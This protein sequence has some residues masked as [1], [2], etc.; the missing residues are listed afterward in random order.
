MD[1]DE[2]ATADCC[3]PVVSADSHWVFGFSISLIVVFLY[4]QASVARKQSWSTMR[5]MMLTEIACHPHHY[6]CI[7]M[8]EFESLIV[9]CNR[10]QL[11][12]PVGLGVGMRALRSTPEARSRPRPR[13]TRK[14]RIWTLGHRGKLG[15]G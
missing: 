14:R 10:Y 13:G 12:L 9:D 15:A 4:H 3:G 5:N 11:Q 1:P 8:L 7:M 6:S 2:I